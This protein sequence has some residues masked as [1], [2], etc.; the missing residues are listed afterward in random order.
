MAKTLLTCANGGANNTTSN[1]ITNF[2]IAGSPSA[3]T[4]SVE[5]N[6]QVL[7]KENGVLSNL[8]I[9]VRTNAVT[10]TSPFRVRKNGAN[11]TLVCNVGSSATGAFEDT[12]H[13][14]TVAVDDLIN[15]QWSPG[16]TGAASI[17][18]MSVLFDNQT[19]RSAYIRLAYHGQ[20][21]ST[22]ETAANTSYY[23]PFFGQFTNSLGNNTVESLTQMLF[24][25]DATISNIA[26]QVNSNSRTSTTTVKVRKNGADGNQAFNIGST[27]TG[28]FEDTTNSDTAIGGTDE[29][30]F[31]IV[32]GA[33]TSAISWIYLACDYR[34]SAYPGPLMWS[35][36][37][38][39][40]TETVPSSS[41]RFSPPMG[42]AFLNTNTEALNQM[43]AREVFNLDKLSIYVYTN[44]LTSSST[45]TLR[46]NGANSA[47]TVNIGS[48]ATGNIRDLTHSVTT[49]STSLLNYRI[50]PG[51]TGTDVFISQSNLWASFD[52][53][54]QTA[55]ITESSITAAAATVVRKA[56]RK[57]MTETVTFGSFTTFVKVT[58]VI[59]E[60]AKTIAAIIAKK[61]IRVVPAETV[62]V[63]GSTLAVARKYFRA[64]TASSITV[65]AA[66]IVKKIIRPITSEPSKTISDSITLRKVIRSILEPAKTI[67]GTVALKVVRPITSE[68]AKSVSDSM[69]KK[70]YK[71]IT[72]PSITI[73]NTLHLKIIRP[74]ANSVS[75]SSILTRVYKANKSI[76]ETTT[77]NVSS[78][79]P[80]KKVT[81]FLSESTINVSSSLDSKTPTVVTTS[82]SAISV[83][84]A[85]TV[86]KNIRKAIL[87]SIIIS[88]TM[89]RL[90]VKRVVAPEPFKTVTS[91]LALL[92]K[93]A[94]TSEPSKSIADSL[95]RKKTAIPNINEPAKTISDTV[96]KTSFFNR[97]ISESAINNLLD[98]IEMH[99]RR[100]ISITEP[101]IV[102]GSETTT[103]QAYYLRVIDEIPIPNIK[104]LIN[105]TRIRFNEKH[106]FKLGIK[107]LLKR[108][109]DT[110]IIYEERNL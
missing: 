28:T 78:N 96:N 99:H 42:R 17:S 20:I 21:G 16:T 48:S 72:E 31:A 6:G 97:S 58:R 69:L 82:E 80:P 57:A 52:Y 47:L 54:S 45:W 22:S 5:A 110:N 88:D 37:S 53:P 41:T 91:T 108:P 68:P 50:V 14:D 64:I 34:T 109:E 100:F 106:I 40:T 83:S 4:T 8:W 76:T 36:G 71:T 23:Y 79:N 46:N 38:V 19:S 2:P 95:T 94:I 39:N 59:S 101:A 43:K 62:T 85:F 9:N 104:D 24:E 67:T 74:I 66:T 86:F 87:E 89:T 107:F 65:G 56:L 12:T 77:I 73:S 29:L 98:S 63:N 84:D 10:A 103:R 35:I 27:A 75:S 7:F 90:L 60:P 102:I 51:G 44:T 49:T 1:V 15:Y 26:G 93:R 61:I 105:T 25:Y 55:N 92:I 18:V 70:A 3:Q 11:T 13:T 33:G 32:N 30:N 81:H